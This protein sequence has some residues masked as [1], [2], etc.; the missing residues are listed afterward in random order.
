MTALV[1]PSAKRPS[2][3]PP[4]DGNPDQPHLKTHRWREV[5]ENAF[6]DMV[7]KC[8]ACGAVDVD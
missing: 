7:W 1:G 6:G 5:G 3:T 2:R 8:S 4:C